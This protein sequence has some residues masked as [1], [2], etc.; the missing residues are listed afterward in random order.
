MK[1]GKENELRSKSWNKPGGSGR[2]WPLDS[3][4]T[5]DSQEQ[6]LVWR[7]EGFHL[8]GRLINEIKLMK[9]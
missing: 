7:K 4:E 1:R 2:K 3:P 6:R 5:H 9:I 8:A